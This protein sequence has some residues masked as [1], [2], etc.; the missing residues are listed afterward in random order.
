M[1]ETFVL[2]LAQNAITVALLLAA[3]ILL[4]SLLVGSVISLIQA[5]TQ[6]NEVT[7]T[8]IPKM[9]GIVLVLLLLG[10]WMLQQLVNFTSGLFE[11]LPTLVP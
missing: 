2:S 1:T 4:V 6:I 10:S 8:F 3:P 11:S 9:I 5:D 7:L